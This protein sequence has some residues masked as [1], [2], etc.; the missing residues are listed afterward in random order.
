MFDVLLDLDPR[1]LTYGAAFLAVVVLALVGYT[2]FA[3]RLGPQS[4][5]KK[6]LATV[7]GQ[8]TGRSIDRAGRDVARR[9]EMADKLKQMEEGAKAKRARRHQIRHEIKQAG[10]T[11]SVR[12]YAVG[13][14]L[15][16]L[17]GLAVM[18]AFGTHLIAALLVGFAMGLGLPK[19]SLSF[20]KKRRLKLFTSQFAD[21]LDIIVRGIQSGLPVG[22]CLTIIGRESP[23][24]IASEFRDIVDNIK[25]G[26]NLEDC[27]NRSLERMPSQ[28]LRFFSIVLQIQ[29]QTG[30]NL[31]ETLSNLSTVLRD[32]KK[33]K[34][35]VKAMS[36]EANTSAMIIGSLPFLITL[37]LT[38][39]NPTYISILFSDDVGNILIV[40]G[41]CWMTLGVI[42]MR[43][44]VSFEI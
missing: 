38:L 10:L 6:R 2:A 24:P 19:F 11:I 39:V 21:A 3:A 41:L 7:A 17:A 32:R 43:N 35:K 18:V 26:L 16:G 30:G 34:D 37:A 36:A 20:M 42:I 33:M 23:E 27:L 13:S 29:Q 22:E 15:L 9:R 8:S 25:L 5:F 31:A 1:A 44:M 40:I 12:Q 4:R 28:E 14:V